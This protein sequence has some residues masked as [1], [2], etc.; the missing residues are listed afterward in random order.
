MRVSDVDRAL[1]VHCVSAMPKDL[2]HRCVIVASAAVTEDPPPGIGA[3][4]A[5]VTA[6]FAM[7]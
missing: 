1:V 5:V 6:L 2:L 3:R 7:A 4:A